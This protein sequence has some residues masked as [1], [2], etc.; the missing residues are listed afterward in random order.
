MLVSTAAGSLMV[1]VS[2]LLLA[3]TYDATLPRPTPGSCDGPCLTAIRRV[4]DDGHLELI[5]QPHEL[6]PIFTDFLLS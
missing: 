1:P 2:R 6:A 5:I 3:D 4:H